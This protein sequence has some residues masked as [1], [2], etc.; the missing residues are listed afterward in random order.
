MEGIR[1]NAIETF[2]RLDQIVQAHLVNLDDYLFV[3]LGDG[4]VLEVTAIEVVDRSTVAKAYSG[5]VSL[6]FGE[7]PI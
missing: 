4:S 2:R 7:R 5:K 3:K 6:C 1:V